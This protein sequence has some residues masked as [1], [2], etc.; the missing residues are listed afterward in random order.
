LSESETE[1]PPHHF[2]MH[3]RVRNYEMDVLGHVNNAIYLHYLEQAAWEH[4]EYLG[5]TLTD[6]DRIGGIF[7][8]R[9]ME[10]EYLRPA[11][12]GDQLEISTWADEMRGP[13]AVRKYEI[14]HI[15]SGKPIV[16]ATG[17]WA[18]VERSSGRPRPIPPFLLELFARPADP[19]RGWQER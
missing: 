19:T 4:S 18:W 15:E 2:V 13:R 5:L 14:I 17:L 11:V 10:I 12:V 16:R 8:L 3:L 6:Y 9:R 1:R 7:I